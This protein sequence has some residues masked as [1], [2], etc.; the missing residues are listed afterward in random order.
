MVHLPT[1]K[2]CIAL[3][4][5]QIYVSSTF[6]FLCLF[7]QFSDCTFTHV[8]L[9]KIAVLKAFFQQMYLF[10]TFNLSSSSWA[11]VRPFHL[12]EKQSLMFSVKSNFQIGYLFFCVTNNRNIHFF[13]EFYMKFTIHICWQFKCFLLIL[14]FFTILSNR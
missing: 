7:D 1:V 3:T 5:F 8:N 2:Y 11:I 14:F 13:D 12:S 9:M 4:W 10:S 6:P